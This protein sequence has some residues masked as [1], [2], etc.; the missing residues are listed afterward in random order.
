MR[1]HECKIIGL[2]GGIGSGKSVVSRILRLTG[3]R[4]YDC[5]REA[6]LLMEGNREIKRR[7]VDEIDQRVVADGVID[8]QLLADIV[9]TD[10]QARRRLNDIV[11]GAVRDDVMR[12]ASDCPMLFV[13][14]AILAESGLAALCDEIWLVEAGDDDLRI[15]RVMQRNK[16]EAE[17]IRRRIRSQHR[18]ADL[19]RRHLDKIVV[20]DNSAQSKLIE[21]I[22]R[23]LRRLRLKNNLES[24]NHC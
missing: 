15:K 21:Q 10:E 12:I 5:D 7:L 18:E 4:V 6:K 9:F 14:S 23:Q 2:T 8:R 17:S 22:D 11:H 3:E 16:C 20:I 1:L 19:L 24:A 13:E